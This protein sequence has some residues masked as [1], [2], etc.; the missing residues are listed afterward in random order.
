M[1]GGKE[2]G[3]RKVGA[4]EGIRTLQH[5]EFEKLKTSLLDGAHEVPTPTKYDGKWF[6]RPDGSII[7]LRNSTQHGETIEVIKSLDESVLE[8]GYKVHFDDQ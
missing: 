3:I 8:N 6:Q 4:N 1:P 7:G 5:S 2:L